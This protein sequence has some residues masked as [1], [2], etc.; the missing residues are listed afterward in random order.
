MEQLKENLKAS[1][2]QLSEKDWR[3]AEAAIRGPARRAKSGAKKSGAK[4]GTKKS[5]GRARR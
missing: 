5:R 1:D 2:L 3:E 4:S